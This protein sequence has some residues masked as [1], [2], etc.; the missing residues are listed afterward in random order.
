MTIP[1]ELS[2]TGHGAALFILCSPPADAEDSCRHCCTTLF[3]TSDV[4]MR[5]YSK[6]ARTEWLPR[7]SILLL[8]MCDIYRVVQGAWVSDL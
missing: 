8:D 7:A 4:M 5:S 6:S 1:T 3:I 2:K